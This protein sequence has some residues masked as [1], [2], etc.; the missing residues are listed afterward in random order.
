MSNISLSFR[1]SANEIAENIISFMN[2]KYKIYKRTATT[3][4]M[5]GNIIEIYSNN[6]YDKILSADDEDGYLYYRTYMDFYPIDEV[7]LT[8]QISLAKNV[9]HFFDILGW[10]SEIIAEFEMLI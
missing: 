6:D 3:Y 10:K 2:N 8:S 9:K 4:I 7:T 5:L 1:I